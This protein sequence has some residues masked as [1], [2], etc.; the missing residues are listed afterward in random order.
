MYPINFSGVEQ[1]NGYY[2]HPLE[3]ESGRSLYWYGD[4][5]KLEELYNTANT[6]TKEE[7]MEKYNEETCSDWC[8]HD[9]Y[10]EYYG[11]YWMYPKGS[12]ERENAWTLSKIR[13][14]EALYNLPYS[15]DLIFKTIE[16]G[17]ANRRESVR[18]TNTICEYVKRKLANKT[19]GISNGVS[20]DISNGISNGIS[21]Y[22]KFGVFVGISELLRK[23]YYIHPPLAEFPDTVG[24]SS[25]TSKGILSAKLNN[26]SLNSSLRD[27]V[28]NK[29]TYQSEKSSFPQSTESTILSFKQK[30][31]QNQKR[32]R[33]GYDERFNKKSKNLHVVKPIKSFRQ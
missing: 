18:Y 6:M 29:C 16:M 31:N 23:K 11:G 21:N 15:H 22:G 33:E 30:Q 25:F 24:G 9:E 8:K 26:S 1:V 28:L 3:E 17:C 10:G 19:N 14:G 13:N 7:F 2:L 4:F 20:N 12:Y 5:Q 32:K 27:K